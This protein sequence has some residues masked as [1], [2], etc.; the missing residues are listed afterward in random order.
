MDKEIVELLAQRAGLERPSICLD[1][2]GCHVQRARGRLGARRS[3]GQQ[4][5][6]N[7]SHDIRSRLAKRLLYDIHVIDWGDPILFPPGQC[8]PIGIRNEGLEPRIVGHVAGKQRRVDLAIEEHVH[9]LL[10]LWGPEINHESM[11][12]RIV[13]TLQSADGRLHRRLDSLAEGTGFEPLVAPRK[14]SVSL[15]ESRAERYLA[16]KAALITNASARSR[17]CSGAREI[18]T[19]GPSREEVAFSRGGKGPEV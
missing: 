5:S 9:R 2:A 10:P 8:G 7:L 11:P 18:R 4:H 15:A 1:I 12:G 6:V 19:L 3:T 17:R 14:G 13:D 16:R